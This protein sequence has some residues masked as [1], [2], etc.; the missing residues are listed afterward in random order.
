MRKKLIITVSVIF[1][2]FAV[3]IWLLVL[4][5]RDPRVRAEREHG[6]RLPPSAHNIQCRG[7]ASRGFLDRGAATMFEMSTNEMTAFVAQL[8]VRL[9][10]LP[11]RATGDP[12]I[13]GYN[14]WPTSA[15]TVVPGNAQYG[16]FRRTWQGV[17]VP[18]EMLSC[19]SPKGDWLHVEFWRL[20]GGAL[21]VKM[22]TDWN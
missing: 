12:T 10:T 19:S 17:A 1:C 8:Q 20:E 13:N 22:Y 7:D 9:R 4:P 21:L 18:V 15:A 16:G 11:A 3:A 5:P 6:V 14:V 2:I